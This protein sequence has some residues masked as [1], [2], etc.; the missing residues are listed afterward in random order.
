MALLRGAFDLATQ[1]NGSLTTMYPS[2]AS[3][4]AAQQL[5]AR[6]GASTR[7]ANNA[8]KAAGKP[9]THGKVGKTRSKAAAKAALAAQS[10]EGAAP[11]QPT[12]APLQTE[13]G[14][15][16]AATTLPA[17]PGPAH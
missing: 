13:T 9:E 14:L 6:K 7:A 16:P 11:S 15:T 12:V 1:V 10:A 3:F 8:A 4:L 5:I 17:A 2:L